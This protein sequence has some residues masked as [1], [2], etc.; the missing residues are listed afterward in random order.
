MADF[1]MN[2]W[3]VSLVATSEAPQITTSDKGYF[4][5]K[6]NAGHKEYRTL[7][8]GNGG[9]KNAE[10]M[11]IWVRITSKLAH[12]GSYKTMAERVAENYR[13][14]MRLM[15]KGKLTYYEKTSTVVNADGTTRTVVSQ[16]HYLDADMIEE[17]DAPA[18]AAAAPVAHQALPPVHYTAPPQPVALVQP[19]QA[20]PLPDAGVPF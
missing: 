20:P 16:E 11:W 4:T 13:K 2:S 5:C 8:D 12:D 17:L 18:P 14:G 15:V 7:P 3:V 9:K 10:P 19:I 1:K 6:F